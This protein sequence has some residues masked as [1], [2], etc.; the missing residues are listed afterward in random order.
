MAQ[1]NGL[2]IFACWIA[3][4][5]LASTTTPR[6]DLS[7][8]TSSDL[9]LL[10]LIPE[11]KLTEGLKYLSQS[12]DWIEVMENLDS[13]VKMVDSITRDTPR[14]RSILFNPVQ[15]S[16]VQSKEGEAGEKWVGGCPHTWRTSF[17]IFQ[18]EA[19]TEFD[20]LYEDLEWIA[21]QK[22]DYPGIA[23]RRTLEKLWREFWGT[24]DAWEYR[25]K[26]SKSES[27]NWKRTIENGLSDRR[28]R[29]YYGKG[30]TDGEQRQ[31]DAARLAK[32]TV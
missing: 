9:S 6:G 30:E 26:H 32:A 4:I 22:R 13:N 17:E 20:R 3:L 21:I 15:S 7:K 29:L 19:E 12:L 14:E 25:R 5:E 24:K 18:K 23:V 16:S 8:Y 10:T 11:G 31:I 2:E 1:K 27:L 28:H